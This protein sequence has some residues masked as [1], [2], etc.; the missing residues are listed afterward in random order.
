MADGGYEGDLRLARCG[1]VVLKPKATN[2]GEGRESKAFKDD[3]G[4]GG[5]VRSW[6]KLKNVSKS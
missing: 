5:R 1:H 6:G 4:K 2:H 3:G